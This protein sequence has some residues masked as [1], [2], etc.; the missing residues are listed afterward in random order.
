ME[1]QRVGFIGKIVGVVIGVVVFGGW[2]LSSIVS[3]RREV[4]WNLD[5]FGGSRGM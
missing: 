2:M 3:F 5:G 4:F 1:E